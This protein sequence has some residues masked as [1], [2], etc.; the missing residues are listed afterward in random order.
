LEFDVRSVIVP[1]L[2]FALFAG[3]CDRQSSPAPQAKPSAQDA[4]AEEAA[5][6]A[7]GT[8][9]RSHKG[10]AMP[11]TRFEGPKGEAVTLADFKGKPL[12][13]NL[14]ATWCGPCV[15]EM[16]T[17]DALAVRDAAKLQVMVISQDMKGKAQVGPWWS[18]RSFKALQPYLE[19]KADLSFG[20]GGGSLPV[21]I[22]FDA[23]GKEVWRFTGPMDWTSAEAAKLIAEGLG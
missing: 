16:P 1:V 5:P 20:Y 10:M 13:V 2:A 12:L 17:L 11:K 6:E 4:P 19:P 22:L 3:G 8:V 14:W 18:K 21:T 9:D 23:A 7:T 15:A